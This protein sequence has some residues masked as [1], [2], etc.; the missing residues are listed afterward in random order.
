MEKKQTGGTKRKRSR[1][2]VP[3]AGKE[4]NGKEKC[5]PPLY[6]EAA[7]RPVRTLGE[8]RDCCCNPISIVLALAREAGRDI[9]EGIGIDGNREERRVPAESGSPGNGGESETAFCLAGALPAASGDGG[10]RGIGAEIASQEPRCS[11]QGLQPPAGLERQAGRR[12][13]G[14]A[15]LRIRARKIARRP[16]SG[17]LCALSDLRPGVCAWVAEVTGPDRARLLELGFV[18]GTP[19]ELVRAAPM[20]DPL[21]VRLR[22]SRISLRREEADWVRVALEPLSR[23]GG[24]EQGT[25]ADSGEQE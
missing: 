4:A 12:D 22:G 24:E 20:G 14:P 19:V 17:E 10:S 8:A 9:H 16:M 21:E 15:A 2:E 5:R 18:P 23:G 25:A 6:G 3:P 11:L 13:L 7:V 1:S